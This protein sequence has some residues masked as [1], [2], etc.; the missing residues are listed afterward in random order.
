MARGAGVVG[1]RRY[2][3][4][5]GKS[6]AGVLYTDEKDLLMGFLAASESLLDTAKRGARYVGNKFQCADD[7]WAPVLLVRTGS[8]QVLPGLLSGPA[9]HEAMAEGVRRLLIGYGAV[10]AALVMSAWVVRASDGVD[11]AEVT[12][13]AEHPARRE[14]LVIDHADQSRARRE[15]A[16]IQRFDSRPPTLGSFSG[17][18]GFALRSLMID[19]L[20]QGVTAQ[21]TQN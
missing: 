2:C 1:A 14:C 21:P 4:G 6:A 13:V 18:E 19:A 9:G 15:M 3:E 20:R 7:D 11:L 16:D 17:T 10:E 8:G 12:S 5:V